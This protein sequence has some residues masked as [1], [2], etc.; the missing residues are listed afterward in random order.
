MSNSIEE[1]FE[2]IDK[3]DSS[4]VSTYREYENNPAVLED[5]KKYNKKEDNI[6]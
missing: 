6:E 4:I 3:C 2:G 5:F 1:F